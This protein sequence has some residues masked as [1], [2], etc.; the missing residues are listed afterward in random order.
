MGGCVAPAL[1]CIIRAFGEVRRRLLNVCLLRFPALGVYRVLRVQGFDASLGF[2][3][4]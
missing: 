4:F 2:R 1:P 3:T